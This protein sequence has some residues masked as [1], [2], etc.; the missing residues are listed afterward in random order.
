MCFGKH[1]YAVLINDP[2]LCTLQVILDW[3]AIRQIGVV[4]LPGSRGGTLLLKCNIFN[5]IL[6]NFRFG[7]SW[8]EYVESEDF[9]ETEDML[10][11]LNS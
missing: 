4:I 3:C 9:N 8:N 11:I 6:F 7:G 5:M 10:L 1:V 2:D